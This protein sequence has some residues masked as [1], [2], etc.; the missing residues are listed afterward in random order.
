MCGSPTPA[1]TRSRLSGRQIGSKAVRR[2]D[3]GGKIVFLRCVR[4][5]LECAKLPHRQGGSS[6]DA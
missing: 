4:P 1:A 2:L 6:E 3:C 5:L